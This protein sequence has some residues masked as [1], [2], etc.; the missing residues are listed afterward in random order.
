MICGGSCTRCAMCTLPAY[1]SGRNRATQIRIFVF[2]RFLFSY[3]SLEGSLSFEP[4]SIARPHSLC[5]CCISSFPVFFLFFFP[6]DFV[7]YTLI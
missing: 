3:V 7:H 1:V 2:P 4:N 5:I 6:N